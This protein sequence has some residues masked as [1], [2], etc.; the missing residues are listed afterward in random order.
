MKN[1]IKFLLKPLNPVDLE[2]GSRYPR[3]PY[4]F[5][6]RIR[7]IIIGYQTKDKYFFFYILNFIKYLILRFLVLIY[8]P[9]ILILKIFKYKFVVVNFWQYGAF[10]QQMSFLIRDLDKEEI[11]KYIVYVPNFSVIDRSLLNIFKKKINIV[12][13]TFLCII[14]IP[15][16]H[17]N[18]LRK[19]ILKYDEHFIETKTY[20]IN[21]K[22]DN[23]N[24]S[25][26]DFENQQKINLENSFFD[27]FGFKSKDKYIAINLRTG[28]FYKDF[29]YNSRNSN[30]K[31]YLPIFEYLKKKNYKIICFNNEIKEFY[32]I[33]NVYI[34]SEYVKK[35]IKGFEIFI[36]KETDLF[37]T[38]NFGPKNVS[39]M[40]CVPTLVCDLF[41]YGSLIP[42]NKTSITI[43]KI[44]EKDNN[45]LN[46]R[47]ILDYGYFYGIKKTENINLIENTREDIL[48]GLNEILYISGNK[49][50]LSNNRILKQ[51]INKNIPCV[52][53]LGSVSEMFLEKNKFLLK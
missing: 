36:L 28:S 40:L 2:F 29:F 20:K 31:K 23:F 17:S 53:G 25:Y 15:L 34:Y 12:S 33:E 52:D 39:S 10:A 27:L 51:I 47:E 38:N 18:L 42:Y 14:L 44:I 24:K 37:I 43:P 32:N 4:N 48:N 7:V 13:N 35:H 26:F 30:P 3:N 16:F 1:L 8:F 19:S 6:E 21:Q 22:I 50:N 49:N 9:L 45:K 11:K 46:F 41:P 5:Y